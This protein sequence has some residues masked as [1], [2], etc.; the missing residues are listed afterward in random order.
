[1]TGLLAEMRR[2]VGVA[3]EQKALD[4]GQLEAVYCPAFDYDVIVWGWDR[5]PD[6]P[7]FCSA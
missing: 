1:M 7:N 4:E 3:V 5:D 2:E 6:P